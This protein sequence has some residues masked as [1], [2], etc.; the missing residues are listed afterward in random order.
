M[1]ARPR[2]IGA[3]DARRI[4]KGGPDMDIGISPFEAPGVHEGSI[5]II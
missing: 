3:A 1:V 4:E 5:A 2:G